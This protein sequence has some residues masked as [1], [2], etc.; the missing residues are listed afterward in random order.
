[1]RTQSRYYSDRQNRLI[2][3]AALSGNYLK[4]A[5]TLARQFKRPKVAILAKIRKIRLEKGLVAEAAPTTIPVSENV[6][7]NSKLLKMVEGTV[8]SFNKVK[9]AEMHADHIRIFF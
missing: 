7:D 8:I 2:E 6:I 5:E 1:M 3:K 9:K 4:R